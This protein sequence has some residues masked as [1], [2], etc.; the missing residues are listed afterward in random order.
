M[1]VLVEAACLTWIEVETDSGEVIAVHVHALPENVL[2]VPEA[3]VVPA[4]PDERLDL[5]D[6]IREVA[7]GVASTTD[8]PSVFV[9]M[10]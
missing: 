1:R 10:R 9:M 6:A 2:R 3:D 7:R 5:T 4:D 8:L